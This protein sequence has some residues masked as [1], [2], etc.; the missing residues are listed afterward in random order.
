M[1]QPST[2]YTVT[3]AA[4]VCLICSVFV[5]GASV[6]L[7]DLQEANKVLDR[8]KK[9]LVVAGLMEE[10]ASLTPAQVQELFDTRIAPRLVDLETGNFVEKAENGQ[11]ASV[12]DQRKAAKD[13]AL[14]VEVEPNEAKVNR[15]AKLATV[16]LVKD[17]SNVDQ[18]ILPI[19][20]AGLW[21]TLYGYLSVDKDGN[22]IRGITFYEHGET[23]GLG[24]EIDNPSWKKKWEGRKAFDSSGKIAI[25]VKKGI[26]GD[27]KADPHAVDGLSGATLTSKGVTASLNFWLGAQ[28]FDSYLKNVKGGKVKG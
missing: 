6:A 20:G 10:G 1:Q 21:S 2:G 3:F 27:A 18:H 4:G 8:Q 23:P 5:S 9:V 15:K 16:Y 11:D 13:P 28:G 7:K 14:S 22:T 26:A 19:Q 17:G 12:Y 24:G 25:H